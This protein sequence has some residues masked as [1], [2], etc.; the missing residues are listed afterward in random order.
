MNSRY[1]TIFGPVALLASV[2]VPSTQMAH[3]RSPVDSLLQ[4]AGVEAYNSVTADPYDDG[5]MEGHE[6]GLSDAADRNCRQPLWWRPR[7]YYERQKEPRETVQ[8]YLGYF[9]G[10]EAAYRKVCKVI[11]P[12]VG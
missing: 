6:Q 5:Y 1:L 2:I 9:D 11:R 10:Y 7:A 12:K 8:R 4:A 3:S